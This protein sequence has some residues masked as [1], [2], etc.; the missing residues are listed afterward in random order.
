MIEEVLKKLRAAEAEA[1]A[2]VKDGEQRADLIRSEADSA[3]LSVAERA[4][5]VA[6]AEDEKIML[7]ARAKAEKD[8]EQADSAAKAECAALAAALDGKVNELAL[9]I[10]KGVKNGGC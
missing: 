2:I 8:R 7:A 1:E 10:F 6:R 4:K 9:E 3:C 5:A